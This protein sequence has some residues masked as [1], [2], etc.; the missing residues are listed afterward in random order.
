MKSDT[1]N[2]PIKMCHIASGDLW[3]GAENQVYNIIAG[4][5][6]IDD[7]RVIV[8]VLNKGKLYN[9]LRKLGVETFLVDEKKVS[10]IGQLIRIMSIIRKN[11]VAIVHSHRYKENIIAGM[12]K[13]IY[14]NFLLVKTQHGTFDIIKK[15]STGRMKM[16]RLIDLSFTK[17]VFDKTIGVSVDI[18]NQFNKY[19][20][21]KI[22]TVSN[23]I[24][25]YKYTVMER[26]YQY[27][28]SKDRTIRLTF[29]GRL[30][31]IKNIEEF[32]KITKIL[33]DSKYYCLSYIVGSGPEADHLKKISGE[34]YT[35]SI[36]QFLGEIDNISEILNKTDILLIT[37]IHEG[38]PTV[39]LEA[40]Y[41]GKIVISRS[42]GGIPEVIDNNIN[43]FLY[44]SVSE[45]ISLITQICEN[46]SKFD[47]IRTNAINTVKNNYTYIIQAKRYMDI[48][49]TSLLE[50]KQ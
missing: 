27:G 50:K 48:Y 25:N 14:R 46:P 45:A 34:L 47:Y 43:G 16:Y 9:E 20:K 2:L 49:R 11:E 38:L 22:A 18:S 42:V 33:Y 15:M 44:S 28:N 7:C 8:I 4:L 6:K 31:K 40:M 32:I 1:I 10:L 3:A 39:L 29:I 13:L 37:S 26:G 5:K 21:K 30:V 24:C 19:I 17:T 23:S 36:I 41:F 35:K 12:I